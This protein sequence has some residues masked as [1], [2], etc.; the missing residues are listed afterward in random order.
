MP[1]DRQER[2]IKR[3]L[4]R[5]ELVKYGELSIVL[6]IHDGRITKGDIITEKI[7]L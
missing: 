5:V 3:L 6:T 2:I 7:S 1:E 4:E